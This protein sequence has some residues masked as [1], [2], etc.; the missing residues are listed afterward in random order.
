MNSS[1][2]DKIYFV[3]SES[4]YGRF[5]IQKSDNEHFHP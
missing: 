4:I 3:C 5:Y 2:F 1:S